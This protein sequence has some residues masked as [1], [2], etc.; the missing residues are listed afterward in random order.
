MI[1]NPEL[2]PKCLLQVEPE[3][4]AAATS[5]WLGGEWGQSSSCCC[6]TTQEL[7]SLTE[8]CQ[9][10][11]EGFSR[12]TRS[13]PVGL[14]M[15]SDGGALGGWGRAGAVLYVKAPSA[16]SHS[17]PSPRPPRPLA[18]LAVGSVVSGSP[19]AVRCRAGGCLGQWNQLSV[20]PQHRQVPTSVPPCRLQG[21]LQ[22][23]ARPPPLFQ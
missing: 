20:H 19:L 18:L 6:V 10:G 9:K 4:E 17:S 11:N 7:R 15:A 14:H 12:V 21:A 5:L 1:Q 22:R 16:E 8:A 13:G 23:A 2:A 3:G